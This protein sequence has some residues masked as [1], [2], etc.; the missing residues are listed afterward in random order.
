MNNKIG[1]LDAEL[2]GQCD[3]SQSFFENED[4]DSHINVRQ[5]QLYRLGIQNVGYGY[6]PRQ[7][8]TLITKTMQ[9]NQMD[10]FKFKRDR[11]IQQ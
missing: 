6:P 9:E 10:P 5:N 11:M 4:M 1:Y 8:Q 2:D 7:T 3:I